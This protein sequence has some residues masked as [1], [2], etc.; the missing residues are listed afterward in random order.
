MKSLNPL[1]FTRYALL[2]VGFLIIESCAINPVTGKRQV[3]FMSESQEI[4]LGKQSD[5]AV[6]AQFGLYNND[7]LQSF[8]KE[9]GQEMASISHRSHLKYEFKVVDSPVLNAFALPGGY[10]YF[11]R[12]ILAHFNN[13]AQ[14]AGVLGHEI[15][16]ITAR[17]GAAQQSKQMLYSGGLILGMVLSPELAS[18]GELASQSLGLLFLKFG[19]DDERQSDKLGVEYSTKIGYDA[20]AMAR[21]FGVLDRVTG[22]PEGRVPTFMSTHP[23]PGNREVDVTN[24]AKQMQ[25][26]APGK[27]FKVNRDGYLRMIDGITY[28]EDPRQGFVE[29]NTFYH[30][31]LKFQF[32]TPQGWQVQNTPQQVAMAP[33]D[34]KAMMI[35]NLAQGQSL[36]AAAQATNEQYKFNTISSRNTTVNGLPAIEMVSEMQQQQQQQ[37]QQGQQQPRVQAQTYLILYN[38]LIYRFIGLSYAQDFA[39]YQN[40][41]L[42]TM[43]SFKVLRDPNKLNRQPE[44]LDVQ[45]VKVDNSSLADVLRS[46]GVDSKRHEEFAVLND[47]QLT[48][49]LPRGML[50]KVLER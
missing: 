2:I 30:P 33:K 50:I 21:F 15:G 34:G 46:Y 42:N 3:M 39:T 31:D 7:Q 13:E 22:G 40:T 36:E 26:Q 25:A 44:R 45:P 20:K 35:M 8:I 23:D 41:F 16:H 28:G 11:T 27:N 14:F 47:M 37:Q 12:G 1:F 32:P 19:R 5:P 49:R 24:Y 18:M 29:N 4:A 6:V 48:D 43:R 9:K 17:H 10:V 38:N